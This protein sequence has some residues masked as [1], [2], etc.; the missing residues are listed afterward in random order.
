MENKIRCLV[1]DDEPWAM[2]LISDY[3]VTT[4]DL[5]LVCKTTSAVQALAVAQSGSVDLIFMDI[6]MPELTGIQL[7][8]VI[9]NNFKIIITTAYTIY[10]MDG[11]E[12][13]VVDYLLKPVTYE[14]LPLLSRNC[15]ESSLTAHRKV[16][17]NLIMF[18]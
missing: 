11:F 10:A 2:E 6:Q 15:C 13:D 12:F 4:P 5:E 8:E 1:V 18:S 16:H 17:R 9:R 7:M 3:I 14:Q